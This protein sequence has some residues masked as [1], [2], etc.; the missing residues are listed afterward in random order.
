MP[1]IKLPNAEQIDRL[2]LQRLRQTYIDEP[3]FGAYWNKGTDPTMTRI[4]DAE[5]LTAGVGV[6]GEWV[7]NDFDKMP[8]FGEM[9][10]VTDTYGNVFIRIPKF[11]IKKTD[12]GAF[13]TWA[14]SKTQ[15]PGFYLPWCFWDFTL[16]TEL[17]YIDVGK[18]KATSDGGGTP[19]LESKPD[20]Y[21][22]C[23]QNIVTFRT[24]AAH[25]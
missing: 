20:L 21:P 10:P 4:L 23:N 12:G 13:K 22:L 18:Y 8:I 2:Y 25:H 3:V 9:G 17:S 6:D 14:V 16:E 7:D 15:Y 24:Y 19:K 1:E 11:Y 5:H